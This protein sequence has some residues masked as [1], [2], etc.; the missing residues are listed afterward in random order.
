MKTAK[1]SARLF[2]FV[3]T[4]AFATIGLI[5]CGGGGGGPSGGGGAPEIALN[6]NAISFGNVVLGQTA[7]RSV[8]VQNNGTANLVIGAV[9]SPSAPFSVNAAKSTCPNQAV[10]PGDSCSVVVNF[11]PASQDAYSGSFVIPSNSSDQTI[12]LSG[13]G[14]GL[15]VTINKVDTTNLSAIRIIVS[16]TDGNNDPFPLDLGADP[17]TIYENNNNRVISSVNKTS[18]PVSAALD[19]DY[20]LSVAGI[21]DDIEAS[22]KAFLDYLKASDEVAVVKFAA[23]TQ[24]KIGF[25]T[26]SS[27]TNIQAVEAAIDDPYTGE[28][29][30]TRLY[31]AVYESVDMLSLRNDRLCALVVS[32]GIDIINESVASTRSLDE[33]IAHAQANE[34]FIFTIGLQDPGGDPINAAVMQR[35]AVE[36]GGQY[37]E[38][39]DST[40]LEPIYLQISEILSNQ[41]EII[42][43]AGQ[44][45]G[46]TNDLKV[47]ASSGTL[48]GDDTERVSY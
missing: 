14:R 13:N 34:A 4:V 39:A 33:L 6:S 35:M 46:T 32:D 16:V 21:Q 18:T 3:M 44:A 43:A 7:E 36:T 20:S 11:T 15:N 12:S 28:K 37:F 27:P 45:D 8:T 17:F 47:V 38:A 25:T 26:L 29:N 22:A 10:A 1:G 42:F 2:A 24:E 5:G 48:L 9:T 23:I 19:L 40:E 31:D 30:A 41:Y